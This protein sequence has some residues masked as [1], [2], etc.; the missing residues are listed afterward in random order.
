MVLNPI[1]FITFL[2]V[3]FQSIYLIFSVSLSIGFSWIAM[4]IIFQSLIRYISLRCMDLHEILI[5]K[6]KR[7]LIRTNIILYGNEESPMAW[8]IIGY[9][10][11][12]LVL[13]MYLFIAYRFFFIDFSE[14][15]NTIKLLFD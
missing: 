15:D 11:G 4:P 8:T 5:G 6:E 13:T 10:A 1:I 2:V 3:L 14:G 9:I 7:E 12:V